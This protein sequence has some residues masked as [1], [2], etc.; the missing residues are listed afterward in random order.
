MSSI[1]LRKDVD[2]NHTWNAESV[3]ATP[4]AWET[5]VDA[6]LAALPEIKKFE[7]RLN[8]GVQT[9]LEAFA[10]VEALLGRMHRAYV[11]AGFSYSVDTTDQAAAAMSG[12][13]QGMSGQVM[14]AAAF[15]NPELLAIG[16][17]VLKGWMEEE[18]RLAVYEHFFN[19]LFRKQ[20]HV[21]SG[22]VEEILGMLND[23]FSGAGEAPPC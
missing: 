12:K 23:P 8:E 20:A 15:L 11:Y 3:F 18:P 9:L 13:A 7:G 16:E 2:R 5:E 4:G 17:Q 10:T 19:N 22:E 21:R 6:I 14:A 1:P